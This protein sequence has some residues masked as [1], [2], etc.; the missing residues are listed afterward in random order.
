MFYEPPFFLLVAGL[1]AGI[2]SGKAFEAT[3]K[4][5][6]QAWSRSRSSRV[7]EQ[8]Q[9]FSLTIPF[10]GMCSGIC[11]FLASGLSVYGLPGQFSYGVAV[12]LTLATGWLVWRQLIQLL[13]QLQQG[14]SKAI[15]LDALE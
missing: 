10:V 3:L 12:P 2:A 5:A 1:L 11:V 6:V 14:G 9:G 4:Q 15:D 13:T 7:L 8:L